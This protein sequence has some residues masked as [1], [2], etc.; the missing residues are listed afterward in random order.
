MVDRTPEGHFR[1]RKSP[2]GGPLSGLRVLDASRILAGP[3]LAQGLAD[4]GADVIKV[5]DPDGGDPT[6]GWGPPFVGRRGRRVSAYFV[7][8]NRGKRSIALDL[9]AKSDRQTFLQLA[10]ESDV[11]VE[12]FLPA[13][14]R[15]FRISERALRASNPRLIHV[16]VSG[17]G[18]GP[19]ADTPAF[20]LVLQGE[21]GLMSVTGFAGAEPVRVGVA[22]VDI[23]TALQGLTATLAALW[24]RERTGVGRRIEVSMI[25]TGTAFLSYAAQSFLADGR[26]PPPL[27]S[28]HP[29][30]SPYQ[31]F[32]ARDGW[33]LV[34]V[35]S[36]EM[37][38]RLCAALGRDDLARD[39]RLATNAGRL[40]H[41]DELDRQLAASFSRRSRAAWTRRLTRAGVAV[42]AVRSVAESILAARRRGQV[43]QLPAGAFGRLETVGPPW[44]FAQPEGR[45]HRLPLRRSAPA[46]GEH[47]DEILR[48]LRS[49]L[50]DP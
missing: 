4:L 30:L 17:Y 13:R 12:N 11:L 3:T 47:T 31:A 28:R 23:L 40:A 1:R 46:L 41:R 8:A 39:Q 9:K 22:I 24:E 7:S 20:D 36:D 38:L 33:L 45:L 14:W 27:G 6:R 34:A 43:Q 35:G 19:R 48:G 21:T 29:N 26:Q 42:G 2:D 44:L 5:E 50:P 18:S 49:R 16:T 10:A 15:G 32:P 37:F 25:D